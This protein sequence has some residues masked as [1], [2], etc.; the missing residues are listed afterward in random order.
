MLQIAEARFRG[1]LSSS[2]KYIKRFTEYVGAL[3]HQGRIVEA[4]HYFI[5]LAEL[6]PYHVNTVRLGYEIAI[7]TFDNDLVVKYDRLLADS[8]SD[9][10][11][12]M[13]FRL[14]YY[15]SRHNLPACEQTCSEILSASTGKDCLPLVIE[16]CLEKKSYPVAVKLAGYLK[17][18]RLTLSSEGNQRLKNIVI[19]ELLKVWK[20]K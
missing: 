10:S 17:E 8:S 13:M 2:R 14:K 12:L 20:S 11:G 19:V 5:E 6:S 4:R 3:L 1:T 9:I 18:N 16:V 7:A 15:Y